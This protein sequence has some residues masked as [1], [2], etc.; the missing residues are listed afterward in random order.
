[1]YSICNRIVFETIRIFTVSKTWYRLENEMQTSIATPLDN[2]RP[3][4]MVAFL[5]AT[6]PSAKFTELRHPCTGCY[7]VGGAAVT[8]SLLSSRNAFHE[9]GRE[10]NSLRHARW[11]SWPLFAALLVL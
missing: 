5:P 6:V 11:P 9:R 4:S 7:F 10:A 3:V 1:M 8:N 2:S